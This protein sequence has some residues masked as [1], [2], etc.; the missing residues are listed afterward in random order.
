MTTMP[1]TLHKR[2]RG[3]P[4][5]HHEPMTEC[6]VPVPE[7][8][9]DLIREQA[10]SFGLPVGDYLLWSAL[11]VANQPVPDYIQSQIDRHNGVPTDAQPELWAS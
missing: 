2:G 6:R 4:K 3:R 1:T 8:Q 11:Q 9:M 7:S 10:A 5:K